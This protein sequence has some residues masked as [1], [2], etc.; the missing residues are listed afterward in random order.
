MYSPD[1]IQRIY[2]EKEKGDDFNFQK[3][4]GYLRARE[5]GFTFQFQF[6]GRTIFWSCFETGKYSDI[7]KEDD[8][9]IYFYMWDTA[10]EFEIIVTGHTGAEESSKDIVDRTA[11]FHAIW[12]IGKYFPVMDNV[13]KRPVKIKLQHIRRMDYGAIKKLNF[14][15]KKMLTQYASMKSPIFESVDYPIN[16]KGEK[17]WKKIAEKRK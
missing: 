8:S 15:F 11:F 16:E 17:N 13:D 12:V 6:E 5:F 9:Y 3:V 4:F 14:W 7:I 2:F 10:L 1:L